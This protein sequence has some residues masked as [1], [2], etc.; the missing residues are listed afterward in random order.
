M[1]IEC[2]Y[3]WAEFIQ[4]SFSRLGKQKRRVSVKQRIIRVTIGQIIRT[5][6]VH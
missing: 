1:G 6:I 2:L 4:Q 5:V 3:I